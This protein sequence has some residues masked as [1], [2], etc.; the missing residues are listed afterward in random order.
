MTGVGVDVPTHACKDMS[1][2]LCL[3]VH[4]CVS[5][6]GFTYVYEMGFVFTHV[7]SYV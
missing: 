6:V 7:C 1:V 3:E 2:G 5:G 4:V